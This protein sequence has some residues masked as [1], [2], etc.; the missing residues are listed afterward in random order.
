MAGRGKLPL[1]ELRQIAGAGIVLFGLQ[2]LLTALGFLLQRRDFFGHG[3]G[4]LAADHDELGGEA[5]DRG[6]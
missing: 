1:P 3:L 6:D 4:M 2:K 5:G